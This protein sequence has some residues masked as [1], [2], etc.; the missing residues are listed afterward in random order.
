MDTM[1]PLTDT[2]SAMNETDDH[3]RTVRK[4]CIGSQGRKHDG[5]TVST[6]P[7]PRSG[8][9]WPSI[10][11]HF[12]DKPKTF[13]RPVWK[14]ALKE[15]EKMNKSL[16]AYFSCT[17]TT[18][19]LAERLAEAVKGDL[20]EIKAAV[21]YSDADLNWQD[22]QSRSSVEMKDK[23]SRPAIEG[24]VSDMAQYDTVYVGF[25]I[26]WYV[27]P[28]IINTFLEQYDFSGKTV[29]PFA[30]SGSS[31][32]GDTDKWLRA[33]C[34]ATTKWKAGK[35]FSSNTSVKEFQIWVVGLKK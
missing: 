28:T 11:K 33:S 12:E 7:L 4:V 19:K 18:K 13:R 17:G 21:P 5:C 14:R 30:T 23:K 22:S 16:V 8:G 20:Y 3:P 1:M 35:R 2:K 25:P 9:R 31:G 26:W 6:P 29:V 34:S 15:G 24:T 10:M 27:A 32:M